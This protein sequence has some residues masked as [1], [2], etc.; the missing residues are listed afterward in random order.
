VIKLGLKRVKDRIW[1]CASDGQCLGKGPTNPFGGPSAPLGLCAT[2]E[3]FK[4]EDYSPR[5]RLYLCR[6]LEQDLIEPSRDL[7]KIA[8]TDTACGFCDE[9]C[10]LKPL[11]AFR[12]LREEL[13]E[14]GISPP[15]PNIIQVESVKKQHNVF[16]APQ[17][18]RSK[19]SQ[20][21]ELSDSGDV[22]FFAGCY[23]S[24]RQPDSARATVK[25]LRDTGMDVAS[26]GNEEWCCGLPASWNGYRS[27]AQTIMKRNVDRIKES[28][29]NTVIFSCAECYR[30]FKLDYKESLGKLPFKVLHI[31]EILADQIEKEKLN[32]AEYKDK[33]TYHDPCFL[34]R[35][36]K[37][38]DEPRRVIRNIPNINFIEMERNGRW[39]F[40]CGSGAGVVQAAYP[41]FSR[42]SGKIRLIEAKNV[43]DILLTACPKCVENL[44]ATSLTEKIDIKIY[45]LPVFLEKLIKH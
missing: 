20:N 44:K 11:E 43:A 1:T 8:Y 38:Y 29:A 45:D 17:E 16:G 22:L 31:T 19:W 2:H 3:K 14:R 13:V 32:L 4:S 33:V 18:S 36:S 28:G 40:C 15:N 12:A 30:T 9:V 6:L 39:A 35:H 41:D 26:L 27:L 24:Y 25:I 5:G 42:W 34:G 23:A 21:L 10:T 37:I 7:V